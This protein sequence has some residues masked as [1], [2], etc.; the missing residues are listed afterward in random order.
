[1][2]SE[3]IAQVM[4]ETTLTRI[5]NIFILFSTRRRLSRSIHFFIFRAPS[6]S[7][8]TSETKSEK[9]DARRE[10][11]KTY[12][13]LSPGEFKIYR[14]NANAYFLF[15]PLIVAQSFSIFSSM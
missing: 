5:R 8:E 1:M 6:Q 10:Q 2:D 4:E 9:Y 3:N 13:M 11:R 12:K 7:F 15:Q 14:Y